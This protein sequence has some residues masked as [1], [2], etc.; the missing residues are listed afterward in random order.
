MIQFLVCNHLTLVFLAGFKG[1]MAWYVVYCGRKP[2]VYATWATCHDQL[3]GFP[4]SCYKRFPTKEEAVAA[5]F[6]FQGCEDEKIMVQPP[7]KGGRKAKTLLFLV[8]V[9]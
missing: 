4:S 1:A 3:N 5:L 7:S 6:E 9:V 2:R 8:A